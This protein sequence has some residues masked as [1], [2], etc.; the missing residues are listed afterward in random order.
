MNRMNQ[1]VVEH[2]AAWAIAAAAVALAAN[3]YAACSTDKPVHCCDLVSAWCD[4]HTPPGQPPCCNVPTSGGDPSIS[5]MTAC[6]GG[7]QGNNNGDVHSCTCSYTSMIWRN[8]HCD[9]WLQNQ[10]DNN[11]YLSTSSDPAGVCTCPN[12]VGGGGGGD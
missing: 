9:I 4:T 5:Q 2:R 10:S 3:V 8:N 6:T 7:G 11:S 1:S 12:G